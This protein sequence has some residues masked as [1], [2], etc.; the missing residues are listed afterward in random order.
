MRLR[1]RIGAAVGFVV[2]IA[3][4]VGPTRAGA[5]GLG[6]HIVVTDAPGAS[7]VTGKDWQV[8]AQVQNLLGLGVSGATVW[9]GVVEPSIGCGGDL[10]AVACTSLATDQLTTDTNGEIALTGSSV[11]DT[12]VVLYLSDSQGALDPT[13]AQS[14]SIHTHNKYAWNGPASATLHRYTIG[15]TPYMLGPDRPG[16]PLDLAGGGGAAQEVR[17]EVSTDGGTTWATVGRGLGDGVFP[18]TGAKAPPV[19]YVNLMAGKPGTY[20]VRVL[21]DGGTY[22]D[23]GVSPV[24]TITVTKAAVPGWLR[25]TNKYRTSL[26]LSAV[27]DNPDYSAAIAKHVHWMRLNGQLSHVE[28]A[29]SRGYSKAGNEAAQSSDLSYGRTTAAAA[30]DGWIGAPFHASCLLNSYWSVGG[31]AKEK[32]WAGEWCQSGLQTLD[33][34]SGVK[35][36]VRSTLRS[37]YTFPSSAMKV[38]LSVALNGNESP[39]PVAGCAAKHVG[40]Y[41]SVPVIFRVAEP[42]AGDRGLKK[43]HATLRAKSGHRLTKVCLLTGRTYR[44]PDAASTQLGRLILGNAQTGRWAILLIKSGTIRAGKSYVATLT[45]GALV[46]RTTFTMA[47]H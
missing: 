10:T 7:I 32:K 2:L 41:W 31:F 26:G 37:N 38:P 13:T 9:T 1:S 3:G 8:T 24:V 35:G 23:P 45:D 22:E 20:S 27:A 16:S 39:D 25:R 14:V 5:A 44:G 43:A 17:T 47:R 29:G 6:D 36:P 40:P 15:K 46:Q 18:V 30:V 12:F 33:L 34:A 28:P 19:D 21:D 4:L 42:P 11:L